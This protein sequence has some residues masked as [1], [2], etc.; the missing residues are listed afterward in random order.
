MTDFP[1]L[2]TARLRLR[3]HR[4]EDF[5]AY[6]RMWSDP[7]IVRHIG[8]MPFS[9]EQSW[10]RFLRQS[11]LWNLIGF[12]FFAIEDKSTGA[13]IGDAGFHDMHRDLVPSIE[14]TMEA[15]WALM[16]GAQ[17]KGLAEEAM[18]AALGWADAVYPTARFTSIIAPENGASLRVAEKLGFKKFAET[19]YNGADVILLE[20][21]R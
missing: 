18:H 15:G 10:T 6:A 20:R 19:T 16:T 7:E 8:G 13:Y 11:G 4:L 3:P 5:A 17:G 9:R 14:G 21:R 2:E 12:G 1:R